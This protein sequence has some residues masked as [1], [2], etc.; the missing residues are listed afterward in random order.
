MCLLHVL[1]HVFITCARL[2]FKN[3]RPGGHQHWRAA[4]KVHSSKGSQPGKP[5]SFQLKEL[6]LSILMYIV[7]AEVLIL[8][9]KAIF[10]SEIYFRNGQ[11]GSHTPKFEFYCS[12]HGRNH[13]VLDRITLWVKF[14]GSTL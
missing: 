1:A 7:A 2:L 13:R 11:E 4:M 5:S 14:V 6:I 8:I 12:S 10:V 9:K 3:M